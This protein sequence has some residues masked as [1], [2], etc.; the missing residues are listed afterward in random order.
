MT[1]KI[2]GIDVHKKVLMVAVAE[3]GQE[4]LEFEYRRFGTGYSELRHL[5]AWLAERGVQEVIMES[6][7]QYWKPV[8][9][10]L[11]LHFQLHLAQA[12]SNK[13]PKGRKHDW[14]DTRR[15]VRRY[16]AGELILSFVPDAEQRNLRTLTRH[17]VQLTRDQV[18][19]QSQLEC[20]LE[21]MRIKLSSVISD[22]L[23]ASGYRILRALAGGETNP[24]K[25]A[26]LGNE[27]LK[28]T[29][30]QLTDA[31]TGSADPLHRGLLGLYLD[32]RD[33]LKQQM[34]AVS[35]MAAEHLKPAQDAVV[36]LAELPG[37][38]PESAQQILAEVGPRAA[39][40]PSAGQLA[41]WVGVCPG[42]EESAGYNH[43][44][45]TAKGNKYMRRLLNQAAQAAVKKK[46]SFLQAVFRRLLVRLGFKKA[47]WAIAHRLCVLIWKILHDGVRFLERG[48]ATTPQAAKR[49]VQNLVR[50]FRRLGYSVELKLLLPATSEE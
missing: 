6:T 3:L 14:G 41:S 28:C 10:E 26:E 22:L 7:A 37:L 11:E 19:L 8:W 29:R 20:L 23:G 21:E 13:A 39:A 34:E 25:L 43:N 50:E 49:R 2:A 44:Q 45:A 32:R 1:Y 17:R 16:V 24:E 42:R 12:Q 38:G 40:F 18:R 5:R 4:D 35:R 27:R 36:R 48:A 47:I 46:N 33:V 30:A 15:L 31:L 9:L